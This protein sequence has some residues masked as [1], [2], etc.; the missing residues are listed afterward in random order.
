MGESVVVGEYGVR[1]VVMF[2]L[3]SLGGGVYGVKKLM[4]LV[5]LAQY[6]VDVE[7]R[8][9]YE[10]R[11]GGRPLARAD[12]YIWSYGPM[13]NEVYDALEAEDFDLVQGE[14][15]LEI[16]YAGPAPQLPRPVAARLSDVAAEYGG[17]RPWQL[18]RHVNR[19]LGL[20]VPEKKSDYMGA[21]LVSY[22][23]A[24]GYSLVPKELHG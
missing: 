12:F 24:E 2:L 22:L 11:Y 18:E 3:K 8:V 10:Y 5:F 13:S 14:L 9:V 4:K 20:D 15:G 6:D 19:L 7:R 16:R 21:R 23:Y 1:E 17:W